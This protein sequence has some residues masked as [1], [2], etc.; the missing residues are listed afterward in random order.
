LSANQLVVFLET[1]ANFET[2]ISAENAELMGTTYGFG[3]RRNVEILSRWYQVGMKSGF[4]GVE[5]GVVELLGRVGRMKF[6]RP[7]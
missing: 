3:A 4:K 2:P 1:V 5:D 6:V 7:L